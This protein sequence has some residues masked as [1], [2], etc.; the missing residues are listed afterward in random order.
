MTWASFCGHMLLTTMI[1]LEKIYFHR[2]ILW[3]SAFAAKKILSKI[4]LRVPVRKEQMT[5]EFFQIPSKFPNLYTWKENNMTV[6]IPIQEWTL[7]IFGIDLRLWKSNTAMSAIT[8]RINTDI[9]I[10]AWTIF[11]MG[12]GPSL[13]SRYVRIPEKVHKISK[14]W[15]FFSNCFERKICVR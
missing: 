3:S 8:V 10:T 9:M 12:L 13:K 4:L 5:M 7:Y 11:K 15:A 14:F 6:R 1:Q 2:H